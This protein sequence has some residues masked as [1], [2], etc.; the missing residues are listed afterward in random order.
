M[1]ELEKT[2][3]RIIGVLGESDLPIIFKGALV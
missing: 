1:N 2:L 3:Y